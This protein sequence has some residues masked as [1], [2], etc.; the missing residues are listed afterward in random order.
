VKI[1]VTAATGQQSIDTFDLSKE[2]ELTKVVEIVFITFRTLNP[3]V[4]LMDSTT[5]IEHA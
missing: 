1:T 4:S 5:K 2:D 3:G